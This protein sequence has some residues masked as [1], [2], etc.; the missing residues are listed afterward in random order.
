MAMRTHEIF[1]PNTIIDVSPL[2]TSKQLAKDI[3]TVPIVVSCL[4]PE[5]KNQCPHSNDWGP[6][7][8]RSSA[9]LRTYLKIYIS[10][11][12]VRLNLFFADIFELFG[13]VF[14]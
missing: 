7:I 5:L 14:F 9:L 11:I 4:Q 3:Y 10:V 8:S 12:R 1:N 2:H 13:V 6:A